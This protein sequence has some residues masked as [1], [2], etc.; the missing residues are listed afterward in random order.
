MKYIKL[1]STDL[2]VS[3]IIMGNMRLNE[4][5]KKEA[6]NLINTALDNG[7]NFFDHADVYGSGECE[8]L[9]A[10]AI[11]M[12]SSVRE[13]M[14][15]QG[16]CGI[17]K[18][19]G[20]AY[21]DFS[22]EYILYATD[23]ILKRLNTEYLDT[24]LLHRPDSWMI[25]EEVAEAFAIL[26]K[27]GKVRYFGVSNQ[28]AGQIEFLQ[29]AVTQKI[30][31]NQLQLSLAHSLMFDT[32]L[33]VNMTIPQSVSRE[34]GILEYCRLKNITIQAWSPMQKGFFEGSFLG[35]KGKYA[36]LN[37]KLDELAQKY[38]VAPSTIATAWITS[39]PANIQVV[40]GT[41]NPKHLIDSCRASEIALSKEE[42]Y[43]L[44]A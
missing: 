26:E 27:S 38:N 19:N 16:K 39:H 43:A 10:Q 30:T 42:W 1:S 21:F 5:S 14:I 4:L 17:V 28:N 20:F 35:D 40:A 37:E 18:K 22:K 15:L 29:S 9:F 31:A 13:K 6:E 33:T 24:L 25:P 41:I 2:S 34:N 12:N 3:Q 32:G 23:Q 8:T 7:I 44:Y 11:G 36:K